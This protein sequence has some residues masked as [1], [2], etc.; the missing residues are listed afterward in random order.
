M[1]KFKIGDI[2]KEPEIR[3]IAHNRYMMWWMTDN[4]YTVCDFAEFVQKWQNEDPNIPF[5]NYLRNI[6]LDRDNLM[7]NGYWA[8]L[9]ADSD[10]AGYCNLNFMK[11]LLHED[12]FVQYMEDTGRIRIMQKGDCL[13]HQE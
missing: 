3:K 11:A 1:L 5:D 2:N 12:E 4:R 10:E 7:L 8:F 13:D 6:L 9:N